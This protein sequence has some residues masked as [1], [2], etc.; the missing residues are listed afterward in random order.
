MG[1]ESQFQIDGNLVLGGYDTAKVWGQNLTLP[2]RNPDIPDANCMLVTL[3]DIRMDFKNGAS[4]SLFGNDT[5]PAMPACVDSH[6]DK[7]SL[8]PRMWNTFLLPPAR[9]MSADLLVS[10]HI[11]GC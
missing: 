1:A 11:L 10:R 9:S 4:Q 8:T 6:V 5:G 7:L 3:T 2:T